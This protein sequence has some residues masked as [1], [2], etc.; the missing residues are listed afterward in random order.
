M[1]VSSSFYESNLLRVFLFLIFHYTLFVL[2]IKPF[3]EHKLFEIYV[4]KKQL[5]FWLFKHAKKILKCLFVIKNKKNNR[6]RTQ[7]LRFEWPLLNFLRHLKSFNKKYTTH[8]RLSFIKKTL[9]TSSKHYS[10]FTVGTYKWKTYNFKRVWMIK[11]WG[12]Y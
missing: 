12:V 9:K 4:F 5:L 11:R 2:I 8:A 3:V 10:T 1:V 7:K 6:T